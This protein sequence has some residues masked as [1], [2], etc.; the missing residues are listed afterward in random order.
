MIARLRDHW[1][2]AALTVL[3]LVLWPFAITTPLKILVIFFHEAAH[4]LAAI[5]TGGRIEEISVSPAQGGHAVTIGGSPFLIIS[6]GYLGSLLIGATLFLVALRSR[7]DRAVLALL[8][9]LLILLVVL[10]IRE[11]FP[12]A[13]AIATGAIFLAMARYL[14][15]EIADMTLRVI[16]LTSMIYVPLDIFDD[17]LARPGVRSDARILAENFGGPAMVWGAIWLVIALA[18]IYLTL[19]YGIRQPSNIQLRRAPAP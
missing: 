19:R 16:G 18:V 1:Q 9:A 8:G 3:V 11:L 15:P 5:L 17:S 13:F 2:L 4:G 10:Y 12:A 14:R 7:F 6:A